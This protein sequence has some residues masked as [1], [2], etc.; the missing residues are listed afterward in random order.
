M[1]ISKNIVIIYL[2]GDQV[3]ICKYCYYIY[4]RKLYLTILFVNVRGM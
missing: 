1:I 4:I 3:L 2:T